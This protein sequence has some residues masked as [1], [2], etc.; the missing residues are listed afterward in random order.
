MTTNIYD[1]FYD[2]DEAAVKQFKSLVAVA[3]VREVRTKNLT[4][5]QASVNAKIHQ[6]RMSNIM[7]GRLENVSLDSLIRILYNLGGK[8]T[9]SI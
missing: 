7:R 6:P 9:L 4:Q 3:I 5:K 2:K 8:V 1:L